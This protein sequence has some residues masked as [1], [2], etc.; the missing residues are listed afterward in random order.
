M[1]IDLTLK[2]SEPDPVYEA[3]LATLHDAHVLDWEYHVWYWYDYNY[4]DNEA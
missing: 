1:S 3:F 4:R 2:Q